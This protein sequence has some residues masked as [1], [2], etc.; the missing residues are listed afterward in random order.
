MDFGEIIPYITR[1]LGIKA[2]RQFRNGKG[3]FTSEKVEEL[4][5]EG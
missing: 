3:Q 2:A 5:Y 1:A 4:T